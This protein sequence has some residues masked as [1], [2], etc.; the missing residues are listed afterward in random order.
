MCLLRGTDWVFIYNSTF[1][2]HRL[3]FCVLC[4][5]PNKQRLFPYRALTDWF[6]KPRRCAFTVR[7]G[8]TPHNSDE[9]RN[10]GVA[11]SNNSLSTRVSWMAS[12]TLRPIY[13]PYHCTEFWVDSTAV[14]NRLR[15]RNFLPP[16][17]SNPCST[18]D[19]V[20]IPTELPRFPETNI[21]QRTKFGSSRA[22]HCVVI[23]N[24]KM[25]KASLRLDA[26]D[27]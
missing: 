13:H 1:Y 12:F 5:S 21:S 22:Q 27:V 4:G 2:P 17:G 6:L 16:R 9:F 18:G 14:S 8:L 3:Y 10:V 25:F 15:R 23:N 24:F 7:H 26:T 19:P 11:T 20:N